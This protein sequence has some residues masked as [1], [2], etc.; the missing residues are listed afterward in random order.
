MVAEADG[1][2]LPS[3]WLLIYFKKPSVYMSLMICA[4]G[5]VMTLSGLVQNFAGLFVIRFMIGVTGTISSNSI[6]RG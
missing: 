3:N 2:E 5:T 6:H 1:I 4:W